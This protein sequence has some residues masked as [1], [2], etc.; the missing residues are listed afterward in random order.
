MTL[1]FCMRSQNKPIQITSCQERIARMESNGNTLLCAGRCCRYYIEG[2]EH[3]QAQET[4]SKEKT[5]RKKAGRHYV[6][7]VSTAH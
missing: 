1:V 2:K 7:L 3:R 4:K 6:R 5:K